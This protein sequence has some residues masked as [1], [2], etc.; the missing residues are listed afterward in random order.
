MKNDK[1]KAKP[2]VEFTT[3]S[4]ESVALPLETGRLV[5]DG[6]MSLDDGIFFARQ[7]ET[8]RAQAFEIVYPELKARQ[9][10]PVTSEAGRGAKVF[11]YR[12]FGRTGKAKIIN[13]KANDLPRADINGKEEHIPIVTLGIEYGY[14]LDEI[15]H[16]EKAGVNLDQRRANAAMEGSEITV[17]E[18]AWYGNAETGI[19]GIFSAG[20]GIPRYDFPASVGGNTTWK[21]KI[22]AGETNAVVADVNNAFAEMFNSTNMVENANKMVIPPLQYSLI[23]STPRTDI[24]DTTIAKFIVANSQ[25]INS[26]DDIIP[27]REMRGAGTAGADRMMIYNDSA[28]KIQLHIPM[29]MEY[30]MAQP[31]GLEVTI[32]ARTKC[33]GLA[34]YKPLSIAFWDG[35]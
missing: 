23:T 25:Y 34:I 24:S 12:A 14:D 1:T 22:D 7:L 21:D 16:A 27:V 2:K 17:N 28:D 11:T 20:T 19:V 10:F 29:E 5:Q 6:V 13:G 26:L 15:E 4:G 18:L 8:V 30:A 35:L 3:D 32:P 9:I 31:K 33:G